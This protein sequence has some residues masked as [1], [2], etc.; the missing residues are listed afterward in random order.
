MPLLTSFIALPCSATHHN[1]SEGNDIRPF[2]G[3]NAY[4]SQKWPSNFIPYE[5]DSTFGKF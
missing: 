5:I 2:P 3:K 1:Y 4:L